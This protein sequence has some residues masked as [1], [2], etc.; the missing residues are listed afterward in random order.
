MADKNTKAKDEAKPKRK[1][2][3]LEERIAELQAKA[4][5]R[6][7]KAK[8]KAEA[9]LTKAIT[10]RDNAR[11]RLERA[12]AKVAELRQAAGLQPEVDG[13]VEQG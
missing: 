2:R 4:D 13:D 5:E 6:R 1:A 12:E 9:E 8:A 3:T 11:A 7:A 10:V